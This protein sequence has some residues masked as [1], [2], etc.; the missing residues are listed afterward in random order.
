MNWLFT[1]LWLKHRYREYLLHYNHCHRAT[2]H[3][4]L[5]ILLLL[6]LHYYISNCKNDS[7]WRRENVSKNRSLEFF[8]RTSVSQSGVLLC[9]MK[10]HMTVAV[11]NSTHEPS[12]LK[13]QPFAYSRHF[14]E[15]NH[16]YIFNKILS[17]EDNSNEEKQ[18]SCPL[19]FKR[20]QPPS[21]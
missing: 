7:E 15:N 11:W 8:W 19:P 10:L 16:W 9:A 21:W 14:L 17:I 2:A 6:L 18:P 3:L 13:H 4:Q 20:I 12:A 5:N 1:T